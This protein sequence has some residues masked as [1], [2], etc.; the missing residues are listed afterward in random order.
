VAVTVG[1]AATGEAEGEEEEDEEEE[2]AEAAG[3]SDAAA[4]SNACWYALTGCSS[5]PTPAENRMDGGEGDELIWSCGGPVDDEPPLPLPESAMSTGATGRMDISALKP[6]G[7]VE[8]KQTHT[9][10]EQ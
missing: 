2:V 3:W 7:R 4:D 8:H 10:T 9:H 5:D 1:E 6:A